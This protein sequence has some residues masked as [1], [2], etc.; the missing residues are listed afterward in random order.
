MLSPQ[1]LP[2]RNSTA[3]RQTFHLAHAA[4]SLNGSLATVADA[5]REDDQSLFFDV[6]PLS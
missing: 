5:D 4:I 1:A 6:A 2:K 3:F